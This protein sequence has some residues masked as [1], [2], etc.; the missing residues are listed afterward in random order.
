MTNHSTPSTSKWTSGVTLL[1]V[2]FILIF[3]TPENLKAQDIHFSQ[4][5]NVPLQLNPALTGVFL[6][7]TRFNGNYRAQWYDVPVT[8]RTAYFAVDKKWYLCEAKTRFIGGGLIFNHD[9]A[10]DGNLG[11]TQLALNLAYTHRVAKKH[12]LSAGLQVSGYQRSFETDNLQFD[13]QFGSKGFD[14]SF[15][16]NE[17]F[18]DQSIIYLDFAAGVNWHFQHPDRAKRT[19]WDLGVGLFHINTPQK[20]FWDDPTI[21]LPARFAIHGLGT[22]E[23]ANKTDVVVTAVGAYQGPHTE[24]LIGAAARQHLKL[25]RTK[26]LAVQLGIAYRFNAE[27]FGTGDA[28]I[29]SLEV[30]HKAWTVGISYDINLSAIDIATNNFGGPEI[31]VIHTLKKSDVDFCPS[32]PIYL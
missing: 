29:P 5:G 9:W 15:A 1:A 17:N 7:D 20:S 26:E 18:F 3:F 19:R 16:N 31:S 13:E 2:F 27:G 30:H 11:T 21:E 12:Y 25:E 14:P 8:Y 32:C 23:V 24:Y 22:F 6:G 28:L 10:G 4:F